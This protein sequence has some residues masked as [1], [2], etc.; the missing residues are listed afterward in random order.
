MP[1]TA[2]MLTACA[3][4]KAPG[5]VALLTALSAVDGDLSGPH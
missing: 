3:I 4:C 5:L 1:G 2:E